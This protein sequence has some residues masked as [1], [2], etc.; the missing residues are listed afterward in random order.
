[1]ALY[2]THNSPSLIRSACRTDEYSGPG[3]TVRQAKRIKSALDRLLAH[4]YSAIMAFMTAFAIY[5]RCCALYYVLTVLVLHHTHSPYRSTP[6]TNAAPALSPPLIEDEW[7]I[8]C[9]AFVDAVCCIYGSWLVWY[10]RFYLSAAPQPT[11]PA[12]NRA[13]APELQQYT[14]LKT[15]NVDNA[16]CICKA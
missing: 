13:R 14:A 8:L 3:V 7:V 2:F 4:C 10:I 11:P 16:I 5:R 1:M 15:L 12:T 9:V 6:H